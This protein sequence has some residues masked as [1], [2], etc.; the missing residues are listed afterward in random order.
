MQADKWTVEGAVKSLGLAR[1]FS[2]AAPALR[3]RSVMAL[4]ERALQGSE[5]R[6]YR[7]YK[8]L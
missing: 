1:V 2:N 5:T 7:R 6:W 3:V 8:Y 4:C